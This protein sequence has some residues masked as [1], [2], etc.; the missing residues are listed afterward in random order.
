[1]SIDGGVASQQA[2]GAD[3]ARF[4]RL[5]GFHYYQQRNHAAQRKVDLINRGTLL[6]EHGVRPKLHQRKPRLDVLEFVGRKLP[7]DA[8]LYDVL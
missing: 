7:Q 2:L 3:I 8:V 5:A 1:M 4:H 6:E